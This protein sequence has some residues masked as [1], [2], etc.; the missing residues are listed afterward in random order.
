MH[1]VSRRRGVEDVI[2]A[3]DFTFAAASAMADD[4]TGLGLSMRDAV[5]AL[6][7]SSL[8]HVPAELFVMRDPQPKKA[9]GAAC[10]GSSEEAQIYPT[11]WRHHHPQP[12]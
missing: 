6:K 3:E 9:P 1:S 11:V 7:F 5:D 4:V 12:R 2:M 10:R 8:G